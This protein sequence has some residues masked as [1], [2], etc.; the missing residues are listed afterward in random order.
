MSLTVLLLSH[1]VVREIWRPSFEGSFAMKIRVASQNGMHLLSYCQTLIRFFKKIT[2]LVTELSKH[3][4][5]KWH[6]ITQEGI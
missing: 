4:P 3:N 5:F 1:T 2:W 6:E